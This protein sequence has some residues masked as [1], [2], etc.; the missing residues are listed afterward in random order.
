VK[1]VEQVRWARTHGSKELR[2]KSI[3]VLCT[4]VYLL[5]LLAAALKTRHAFYLCFVGIS[6]VVT[7]EFL[8]QL[9][10]ENP[11]YPLP[12]NSLNITL[13]RTLSRWSSTI[14]M[15]GIIATA[16]LLLGPIS[17]KARE[18]GRD[19]WWC[20]P[21]VVMCGVALIFGLVFAAL[22]D[23]RAPIIALVAS[24]TGFIASFGDWTKSHKL[25]F[26]QL[27]IFTVLALISTVVKVLGDTKKRTS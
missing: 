7:S 16:T 1:L 24:G 15:V 6:S 22:A 13:Q 9:A 12:K 27:A 4:P 11:D 19:P 25:V 14:L 17:A 5:G 23:R 21:F 3:P 20:I 8:K 26:Q 2:A 18:L 10:K